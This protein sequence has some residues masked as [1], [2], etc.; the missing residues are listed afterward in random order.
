MF[1]P[2]ARVALGACALLST[3]SATC[4]A[5]TR[6][7]GTVHTPGNDPLIAREKV[8]IEGAGT[9]T[10]DDVG[11]FDFDLAEGLKTGQPARFHATP[12]KNTRPHGLS[13]SYWLRAHSYRSPAQGRSATQVLE[14]GIL[15][16]RMHHRRNGVGV[17]T[18]SPFTGISPE[19]TVPQ[20][21]SCHS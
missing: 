7:K 9:Y 11:E 17:Q 16:H 4:T 8:T 20:R 19:F 10:T 18:H 5:Q 13:S 14:Q 3:L 2:T 12:L 21:I 1:S 15:H 6:L